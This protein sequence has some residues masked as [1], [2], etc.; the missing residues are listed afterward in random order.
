VSRAGRCVRN[1]VGWQYASSIVV[2]I[3][4]YGSIIVILSQGTR[5]F[6]ASAQRGPPVLQPS[7][8]LHSAA[9]CAAAVL[10][11]RYGFVV[12][13]DPNVVDIACAGLNGLKMGDRTLTVR[14]AAEVRHMWCW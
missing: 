6:A 8:L 11:C 7:G 3:V 9:L 1:A 12:Y 13:S 5:A 10:C 2:M 14:R 4:V